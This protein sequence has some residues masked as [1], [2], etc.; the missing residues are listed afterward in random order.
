MP[1][2]QE[3]VAEVLYEAVRD[4]V[5]DEV[6]QAVDRNLEPLLHAVQSLEARLRHQPDPLPA[7]NTKR[8]KTDD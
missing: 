3:V 4:A 1:R 8:A 5:R 2:R 7:P 6:H